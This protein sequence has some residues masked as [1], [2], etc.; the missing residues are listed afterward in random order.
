[1]KLI[2]ILRLII[3]GKQVG[4][5]YHGTTIN[6]LYSMITKDKKIQLSADKIGIN[7]DSFYPYYSFT[8]NPHIKIFADGVR[9]ELN[10]DRMSDKYKFKPFKYNGTE[11]EDEERIDAE[12]YENVNLM[13]YIKEIILRNLEYYKKYKH[14]NVNESEYETILN[15]LDNNNIPYKIVDKRDTLQLIKHKKIQNTQLKNQI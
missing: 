6:N 5:I 9:I 14:N 4:T 7:S 13:P 11:G 2:K 12:K 15:F 3:E 10:G 1:M 8:R